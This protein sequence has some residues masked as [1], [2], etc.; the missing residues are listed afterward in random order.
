MPGEEPL[1]TFA[2]DPADPVPTRGGNT[3]ILAMGVQDQRPVEEREDVLVY[4]SDAMT[5]PGPKMAS[6]RNGLRA[7]RDG[8]TGAT[9]SLRRI[10]ELTS[11]R[12]ER[13]EP[14]QKS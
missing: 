13:V 14:K 7:S 9:C 6:Q 3:L 2:Y 1:D 10:G 5:A 11:R 8:G 12:V 4:T